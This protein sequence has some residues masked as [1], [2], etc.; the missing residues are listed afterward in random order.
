M[1]ISIARCEILATTFRVILNLCLSNALQPLE[2]QSLVSSIP[3]DVR[4]VFD[5]LNLQPHTQSF[6]CC[7]ECYK[8]YPDSQNCPFLCTHQP[9]SDSEICHTP[10]YKSKVI[11]GV[12]KRYPTRKFLYHDMKAWL[13]NM[14]SRRD[15]EEHADRNVFSISHNVDE[16]LRDI[17]DGKVFR[18]FK[19]PDGKPFIQPGSEEGRYIFSLCMDGFNPFI[20]KEAGK[21]VS[22]GAIYMVLLNLPIDIRYRA[23]N[24]FLVGIIPGPREPSLE[25]INHVLAP[26]VD[27]LLHFWKPGV[28]IKQTAHHLYGRLCRAALIP[29]V[30]DL[31]AA[32]QISGLASHAASHFCSFCRLPFHEIDSLDV[33]SWPQ[34]TWKE[35]RQAASAWKNATSGAARLRLY[36]QTGIRW[37]ELLRLPYWDPTN[38]V[39]L[40]CMHSL[41]LGVLRRHC[42][43]VWGMDFQLDDDE[44]HIERDG[45][46]FFVTEDEVCKGHDVLKNGSDEDVAALSFNVLRRLC[47]DTEVIRFSRKRKKQLVEALLKYVSLAISKCSICLILYSKRTTL[48]WPS[49]T[50]IHK[51]MDNSVELMSESTLSQT[52][53]SGSAQKSGCKRPRNELATGI[54]LQAGRVSYMSAKSLSKIRR[55]RKGLI[56]ALLL[57]LDATLPSPSNPDELWAMKKAVLEKTLWSMVCS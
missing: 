7:P 14:L 25:Q 38:F 20:M 29:I 28:F 30:C 56:V 22:V 8:L 43:D 16:E 10:L 18:E 51:V 52:N 53:A 3:L 41:L 15:I 45:K 50:G 37:S 36:R 4:R 24:M 1:N 17:W 49:D 12:E 31:P 46:S 47:Q 23:E 11:R 5:I 13:A 42:R 32:R 34:R 57:D 21:K 40:D 2:V 39:V 27:D 26:L 33:S 19:G 9:T 48:G 55:F 44:F 6:I 35:H 54:E